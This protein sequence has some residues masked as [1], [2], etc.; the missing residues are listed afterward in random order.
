M[1]DEGQRVRGREG[2]EVGVD[3]LGVEEEAGERGG[4]VE[5]WGVRG[6]VG[7]EDEAVGVGRGGEGWGCEGRVV[8]VAARRIGVRVVAAAVAG[9]GGGG[10]GIRGGGHGSG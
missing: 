5:G 3:F 1:L 4:E 7:A 10:Q 8:D 6:E 9:A 2:V